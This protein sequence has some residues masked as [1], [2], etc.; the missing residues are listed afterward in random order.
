MHQVRNTITGDIRWYWGNAVCTSLADSLIG[1]ALVLLVLNVTGSLSLM[2]LM[3]IAIALPNIVLSLLSAVWVDR[4]R[5]VKVVQVSQVCRAVI[6]CCFLLVDR[7]DVIW[8][9]FVIA[10]VQSTVGTFDDPARARLIRALTTN[11][12]RLSVNSFTQSGRTVASV[13]GTT[14]AGL[15]VTLSDD[16]FGSVFVVATL[17]Y[18]LAGWIV[19]HITMPN[20]DEGTS[21]AAS[22]SYWLEF[23][24]GFDTVRHSP[25]LIAVLVTAAAATIGGGAATVLLT[26]L[27]VNHLHVSPAWFGV[28]EASQAT[29]AILISFAIGV[30]GSRL[31]PRK[32]VVTALVSTG[33]MIG[34]I[35]SSPNLLFLMLFMLLVGITI[36]PVS[37]AFSTLLQ[38]H[39]EPEVIGRVSAVLSMVIE[40]F[41]ILGIAAAG[42]MADQLGIRAVFWLAGGLCVVG[43]CV[44][45]LLFAR[46]QKQPVTAAEGEQ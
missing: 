6:V 10:F 9:A 21:P 43:G 13:A 32:L 26:P 17:I 3:S 23:R 34:L 22:E 19:G 8:L 38:T 18:A 16:S 7:F 27:V 24:R 11:E 33:V 14:I 20:S 25:T 1:F 45:L 29:G 31:D 35:G 12:S 42:F 2:A 40:P 41:S 36:T 46:E 44:A 4:W 15:M 5:P 30:F 28:I 37:S 39:T